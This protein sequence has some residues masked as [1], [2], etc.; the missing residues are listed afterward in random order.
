M[1]FSSLF[2]NIASMRSFQLG[3]I[4]LCGLIFNNCGNITIH[5]L[6]TKNLQNLQQ[7][8]V[9]DASGREG[10]LYGR[11]LRKLLHIGGKAVENYELISS[12][13]F[14]SSSTLSVQGASSTLKKMTMS[15]SFKLRNLTN[16]ETLIADS[17]T[18]DATLG[19]V[20]SLYGQDKS[21]THA[22]KRLAILLA[23]RVVQRLQLYF[24]NQNQ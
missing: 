6:G 5:Q 8:A 4:V 24:L 15:A 13:S 14:S 21:E 7:I 12:I 18:A 17:I 16:G 11:E 22:R 3:I 19:A 1:W 2:G 10:Q 9:E 20:T 23:Q